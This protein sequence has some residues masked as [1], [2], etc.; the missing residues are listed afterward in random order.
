MNGNNKDQSKIDEIETLK[1]PQKRQIKL[2]SGFL[3][4]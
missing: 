1:K 4:R 3:K 2:R